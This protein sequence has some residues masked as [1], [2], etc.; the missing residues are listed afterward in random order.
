MFLPAGS[1]DEVG[2]KLNNQARVYEIFRNVTKKRN[3]QPIATPV[4]EYATTFTNAYAGMQ[5]NNMLKWFNGD[6]EIEVLRPDWTTAVARAL[7]KQSSTQQ[8]WTYQGSV[9][10]RDKP[11]M[12]SRQAGIEVI[13]AS[14]FY[15]ESECLL[16]ARAFLE[17]L[18][19]EDY[20]IELG[21]TGIFDE[22][23]AHLQLSDKQLD[24]LRQ[25]MHDKRKD[26]VFQLASLHGDTETAEALTGLVEAY[27]SFDVIDA[28]EK[29]WKSNERLLSIIQHIKKLANLLKETGVNDVIVDLGRVKNLPYYCGTMFRGFLKQNGATCF[30]GGRYDKL[31]EQFDKG[32][33]AV[34]LAFDV[35]FLSEQ[36]ANEPNQEKVCILATDESLAYAERLRKD[37]KDSIVDVRYSVESDHS[38]DVLVKVVRK[39]NEEWDVVVQ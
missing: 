22:L 5:L 27:G 39:N 21:H 18:N 33:S 35:D 29:R 30:S 37:Y 23:T 8:K 2:N 20:L 4:V 28:Y 25:A 3:Y 7:M 24:S 34:G 11:G 10:V 26:E 9:F 31:Y 14:T 17:E 36:I 13:H 15:G 19:I 1:Q 38:Y 16:T 32:I 12:E 6:G